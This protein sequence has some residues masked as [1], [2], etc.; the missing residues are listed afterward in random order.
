MSGGTF[1]SHVDQSRS[2]FF[3][4]LEP[5]PNDLLSPELD[6]NFLPSLDPDLLYF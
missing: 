5:D 4:S 2:E 6:P 1:D 3:L